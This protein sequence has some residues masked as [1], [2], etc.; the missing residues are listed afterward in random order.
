MAMS[1]SEREFHRKTAVKCFNRAWDYLDLKK[2]NPE[3]NLEMLSLVHTSRYHWSLVGT[4]KNSAIG[5]WLVSRAY[6]DLGQSAIALRYAELCLASCRKNNLNEIEHT[7][8]EAIARAY[9]VANDQRKAGKYIKLARQLLERQILDK[10]D[11]RIYWDQI[12]E[13]EALIQNR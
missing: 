1:R 4:A 12:R 2:R 11:T 3:D 13:T 9:A 8:N 6:S 10:E 7:A 5:D